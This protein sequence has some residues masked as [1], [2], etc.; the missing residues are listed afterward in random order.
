MDLKQRTSNTIKN[1][2]VGIIAQSIQVLS[3]FICR[4]VFV[5]VLNESYLGINGL[6]GNVLSILSLGELG[7]GSAIT[8]ELYRSLAEGN[9][10]ETKS[11]MSFYRKAY[12]Y[13][14][15]FIAF[16]GLLIFPFINHLVSLDHNV[17]ANVYVL[18]AL[19]LLDVV[20]SYFFSYKSSIIEASQQNYVTSVIHTKVIIAQ[21]IAQSICLLIT[22]NFVLYLVIQVFCSIAYNVLVAKKADC[23]FPYL[24]ER[25]IEEISIERKKNMFVNVKDIFITNVSGKLVNSTDN[26]IITALGGLSKTGLNSNYALLYA[27]L[28]TFTTKVQLGVKASIGNVNAIESKERRIQLFNEIHFGFYW[29]YFWFTCCFILLVQDVIGLF[30]GNNYV[31]PFAVAVITGLNFYSAEEGTV[32]TIFKETMGLFSKGKFISIATGIINIFLSIMLGRKYGVQGILVATFISRLL[33]TRWYYPYVT[34]RYGFK[35]SSKQYFIDELRYWS[36][37]LVIFCLSYYVC[38]QISFMSIYAL[39]LKLIICIIL[40]NI[41]ILL[42][43]IKDPNCISITN[44]IKRILF[45]P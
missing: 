45:K 34:F 39:L 24:K 25:N 37:G 2:V 26:I 6:F 40:P 14:G 15:V 23:L 9:T 10:D 27:T 20:I 31:M 18:Y 7:I 22:R 41:M 19:Y 8:F 3:S 29:M 17:T 5:H 28:V 12:R 43:H 4:I 38:S 35:H 16:I 32:V 33:T 44:R 42:F 36:E 30:F 13:I 11:L 21:N 1:S